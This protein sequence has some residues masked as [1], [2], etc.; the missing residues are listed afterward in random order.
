[1][2]AVAPAQHPSTPIRMACFPAMT[3]SGPDAETLRSAAGPGAERPRGPATW[4]GA[5]AAAAAAPAAEGAWPPSADAPSLPP[6]STPAA[7]PPA[8]AKPRSDLQ[9]DACCKACGGPWTSRDTP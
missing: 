4:K 8:P 7:A 5:A 9:P 6:G 1:Q 3:S 2:G